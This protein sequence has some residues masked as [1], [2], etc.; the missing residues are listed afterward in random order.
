MPLIFTTSGGMGQKCQLSELI[1]I[2]KGEVEYLKTMK[3]LIRSALQ[4]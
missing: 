4:R 3:P 1:V 2:K